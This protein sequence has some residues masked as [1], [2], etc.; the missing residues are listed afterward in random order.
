MLNSFTKIDFCY[1][2]KGKTTKDNIK[3]IHMLTS[4]IIVTQIEW[5]NSTDN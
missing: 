4:V 2:G 1:E 3:C 5:N